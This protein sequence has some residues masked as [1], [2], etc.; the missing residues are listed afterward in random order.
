MATSSG[1]IAR[2][3]SSS[4]MTSAPWPPKHPRRH[5]AL[6]RPMQHQAW[7]KG[8]GGAGGKTHTFSV[9]THVPSHVCR[10]KNPP[11]PHTADKHTRTHRGKHPQAPTAMVT[12]PHLVGGATGVPGAHHGREQG[13]CA[14][15]GQQLW[16]GGDGVPQG[17]QLGPGVGPGRQQG[18]GGELAP[19][20]AADGTHHKLEGLR[21]GEQTTGVVWCGREGGKRDRVM[22]MYVHRASQTLLKNSRYTQP[23]GTCLC[24]KVCGQVQ[25]DAGN[26]EANS[27]CTT[28][29]NKR[30]RG[31]GVGV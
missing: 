10:H 24:N 3:A 13:P 17:T 20:A 15:E 31:V 23:Y 27:T 26:R 9:G 28:R 19:D 4:A 11:P 18:R 21:S 29:A 5:R 25:G 30:T 1:I 16:W 12:A 8:E 14:G 7:W 6:Y 22:Y 2:G